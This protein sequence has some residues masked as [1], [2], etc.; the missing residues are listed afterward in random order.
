MKKCKP[1]T[2]PPRR[3]T[4]AISV[5]HRQEVLLLMIVWGGQMVSSVAKTSFLSAISSVTASTIR[6][7]GA[8][9]SRRVVP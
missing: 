7:Q 9:S 6:S 8:K 1:S 2:L 3:V 4:E 5:T